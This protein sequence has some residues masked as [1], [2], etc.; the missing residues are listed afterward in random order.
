MLKEGKVANTN[1]R[2]Q[3]V[4]DTDAVAQ[5]FARAMADA[6]VQNNDTGRPTRLIM[7]VGP[8]GQYRVFAEICRRENID[9]SKLHIFF[10]DEYVG[11]DGA[12]LSD[13]HPFSFAYFLKH[14]FF[15]VIDAGCRLDL[16]KMHLPDARDPG[17][18]TRSIAAAGGIDICFGGIGS[19]GHIAFN[20]AL[21]YWQMMSNEDFINLTTRVVRVATTTKVIN[22]VFG[23]GGNLQAVP[24]L[25]V[26]IGMK[27]ILASTQICI[28]LDWPWQKQ[29]L[30]NTI[31]GPISPMFPASF[32]Q[33][34][35]EVIITVAKCVAED[36]AI[37]PE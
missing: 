9:L 15:E 12:N 2:L 24:N 13:T 4:N 29:V 7:P 10:M 18:H 37:K 14:N 20:E 21:D 33:E 1:I 22:A 8:T 34:H 25:A 32:L 30:R 23:T 31:S 3:I 28:Y 27:E 16:N 17:S 36:P 11:D 5:H 19:D 35:P 6:V 26:T